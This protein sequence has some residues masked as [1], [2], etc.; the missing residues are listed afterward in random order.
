[1]FKGLS[2]AAGSVGGSHVTGNPILA[3]CYNGS[4]AAW[5]RY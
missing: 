5:R 1:M 2:L 3:G 4:R